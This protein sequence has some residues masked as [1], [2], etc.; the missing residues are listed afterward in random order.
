MTDRLLAAGLINE[1]TVPDTTVAIVS[2]RIDQ[3]L[4]LFGK[5]LPERNPGADW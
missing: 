2:L 4:T 5:I 3:V 1:R